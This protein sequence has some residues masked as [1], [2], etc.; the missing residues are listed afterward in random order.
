MAKKKGDGESKVELARK[1]CGL[2]DDEK[3]VLFKLSEAWN[4][5]LDLPHKG[6]DDEAEFKRAIHTAQQ[7]VAVRVA[8]RVNPE[9]WAQPDTR[10][11][12]ASRAKPAKQTDEQEYDWHC[13]HCG[14]PADE[15]DM[16]PYC[17]ISC[18]DCCGCGYPHDEEDN[19]NET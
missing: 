10:T 13:A 4:A 14:E 12:P 5:F 18:T 16:C 9:A 7:L 19:D 15:E 11:K 17:A 2:S 6:P 8:R 3:G 1:A